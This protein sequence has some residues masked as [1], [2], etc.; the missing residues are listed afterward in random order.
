TRG[1][2]DL[3]PAHDC[4]A[5]I[6]RRLL[7][8]TTRTGALRLLVR[9]TLLR[10]PRLAAAPCERHPDLC[11]MYN[12]CPVPLSALCP[13]AFDGTGGAVRRHISR[14]VPE[15][16]PLAPA[17]GAVADRICHHGD[18]AG[19]HDAAAAKQRF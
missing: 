11:A 4:S 7:P 8:A 1:A 3:M 13:H 6:L 5:D 2:D 18:V 16:F 19:E 10:L 14:P 17:G 9:R 15:V 12:H